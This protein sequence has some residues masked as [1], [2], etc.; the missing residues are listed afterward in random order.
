[1]VGD[2]LLL[3]LANWHCVYCKRIMYLFALLITSSVHEQYMSEK[4]QNKQANKSKTK[5]LQVG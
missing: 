5:L 4:Q 3:V 1:M 2:I